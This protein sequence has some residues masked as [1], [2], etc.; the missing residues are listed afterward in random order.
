[1]KIEELIQP[2]GAILLI[3]DSEKESEAQRLLVEFCAK[4]PK[5]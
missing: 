2:E 1:M 3:G 4:Q 5:N